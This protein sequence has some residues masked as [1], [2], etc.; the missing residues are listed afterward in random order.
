MLQVEND[1]LN[2]YIA[3]QMNVSSAHAY[4]PHAIY[5]SLPAE[6]GV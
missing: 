1:L 2:F 5:F 4:F 3:A 6:Y